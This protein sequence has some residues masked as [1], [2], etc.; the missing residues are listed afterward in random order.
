MSW[1]A[2]SCVVLTNLEII[3]RLLVNPAAH[4]MTNAKLEA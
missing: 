2:I 4:G 1:G 3:L